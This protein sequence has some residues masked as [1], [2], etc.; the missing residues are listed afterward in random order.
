MNAKA[1]KEDK[2]KRREDLEQKKLKLEELR[3]NKQKVLTTSIVSN[4]SDSTISS[5][6]STPLSTPRNYI[7]SVNNAIN[8]Q[9]D[10]RPNNIDDILKSIIGDGTKISNP[11]SLKQNDKKK[12]YR[13]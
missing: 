2:D 10:R 13:N 9:A 6:T 4:T 3:K 5:D 12:F 11:L 8:S 1:L 7:S